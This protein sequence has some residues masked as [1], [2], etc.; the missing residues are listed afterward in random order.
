MNPFE[1]WALAKGLW[2]DALYLASLWPWFVG[3]LLVGYV[4]GAW[5]G[6]KGAAV[7]AAVVGFVA[8]LSRKPNGRDSNDLWVNGEPGEKPVKRYRVPPRRIPNDRPPPS[9]SESQ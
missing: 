1:L 4:L 7:I 9:L 6:W 3:F 8:W 5:L 2:N